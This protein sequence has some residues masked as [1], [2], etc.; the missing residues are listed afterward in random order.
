[1]ARS[2]L[3]ASGALP[4]LF[5]GAQVVVTI[6]RAGSCKVPRESVAGGLASLFLVCISMV[7]KLQA[8]LEILAEGAPQDMRRRLYR[9]YYRG[10]G[11]GDARNAVVSRWLK[12]VNRPSTLA[13]VDEGSP[14]PWRRHHPAITG[15]EKRRRGGGGERFDGVEAPVWLR[16]LRSG[17]ALLSRR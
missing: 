2:G 1:M 3:A 4:S 17:V 5:E 6:P 10:G 16:T 9:G 15:A 14:P 8:E 12:A 11:Q 7:D 13:V